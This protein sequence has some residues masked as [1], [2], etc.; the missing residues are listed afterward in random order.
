MPDWRD[1]ILGHFQ[2]RISRLTLVSD[3]D[4]LL[5]EEGMLTAIKERGFDLIPFDD[6]VAFRFAYES[7]YR[8]RWDEGQETDLVVVMRSPDQRLDRL[9]YDLLK[10]GRRL[11]FAL[12][13]LFPRLNYPVLAGLDRSHLDDIDEAYRQHDGSILTPRETTEFLLMHCFRIVPKLVTTPA[14]LLKVLLS[15]HARRVRLPD[16][17]ASYLI[18]QLTTDDTFRDWPLAAIVPDRG[19]FLRFL[20]DEWGNYLDALGDPAK[21]TRVP[22]GHEDVRAYIDTLFL[23]G[24]LVPIGRLRTDGLPSWAMTGVRHDEAGD[25]VRRL[26][27]LR[28]KFERDLPV[29]GASH[30]DWQ[31]AARRWAELVVL[32]WEWD[33]ALN[34]GD[35]AGWDTLHE[36]VEDTFAAWMLERHGSLYNLPFHD[37]PV[38]VHHIPRFLAAER[39]RKKLAKIAL[40]VMDGLAFDQW[41][42]VRRALEASD[43]SWRFGEST[44]FAWVPTLT[45]VSRQS[46]FAGEAPMFFPESF[47]TTAKERGHWQRFWEDQGLAKGTTALVTNLDSATDPDL[48][49]ALGNPR[50]IALGIVWNQVDDIMHGMHLGTAGMHSQVR[51]WASQGGLHALLERLHGEGFAVFLAADHGNVAATGLGTPREGVLADTKGKRARVYD[52]S[53]FRDEVADQYPGTIRWPGHSLPPDRHVLLAGDL[54]AFTNEGYRIVGHGGIALEEVLV[55]FVAIH[56]GDS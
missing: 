22:F 1:T 52:R 35:R 51:L 43:S 36:K 29:S 20:Q 30:R 6:P 17:L 28:E 46:I 54:K 24:A 8:K 19:A 50:L 39:D 4:G 7:Q 13:Q 23:D 16:I 56:K 33:A 5:T 34:D 3:P 10:T 44:A 26:R 49:V 9:P 11:T 47:E 55:P 18:G 32:H 38:M 45:S 21:R 27:G 14:D 37:H 40:L 31:E 12:H 48:E 2:R 42:I 15:L 25:A 53:E 41:I